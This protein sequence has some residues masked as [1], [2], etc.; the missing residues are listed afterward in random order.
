LP[1]NLFAF[2]LRNMDIASYFYA[3]SPSFP[4]EQITWIPRS[5]SIIGSYWMI[6][7]SNTTINNKTYP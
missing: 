4:K 5:E 7:I 6:K 2:D 3:G 1:D